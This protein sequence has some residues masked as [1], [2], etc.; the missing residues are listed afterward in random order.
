MNDLNL[1]LDLKFLFTGPNSEWLIFLVSSV[2]APSIQYIN[3]LV[4]FFSLFIPIMGRSGTQINSEVVM[5]LFTNIT[6]IMLFSYVVS[7]FICG[8]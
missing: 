1:K 4:G 8:V 6:C 7:A 3:M 5:A 2:F